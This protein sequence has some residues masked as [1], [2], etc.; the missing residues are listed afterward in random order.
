MGEGFNGKMIIFSGPSGSGKS[1]IAR[2]FLKKYDGFSFSVS[3]CTR[4]Q[5]KGEIDGVH[6][7]FL[8]VTDFKEMISNNEFVEHEEVYPG[9]FYGT[10]RSEIERIW[11]NQKHILFD[12]DVYGAMSIKRKFP[13]TTLSILVAP[14]SIKVLKERLIERSTESDKT[15]KIRLSK[16]EKELSFKNKFDYLLLNDDL[17][18]AIEQAEKKINEFILS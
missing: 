11:K 16:A 5:R 12:I 3:A 7:Y 18:R 14:P 13:D 4:E 17:N 8:N 6:Y 9:K 15:L 1:T 2:H 10:M